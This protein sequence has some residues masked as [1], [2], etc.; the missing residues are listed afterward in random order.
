[1]IRRKEIDNLKENARAVAMMMTDDDIERVIVEFVEV[2]LERDKS[3]Q[4]TG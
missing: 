3:H 2:K 4:K 1:M